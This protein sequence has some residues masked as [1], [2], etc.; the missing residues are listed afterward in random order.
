MAFNQSRRSMLKP[1]A[2]RTPQEMA[3]RDAARAQ[4]LRE[5]ADRFPVVT[6]ENAQQVI[7]W[8]AARMAE[9]TSQFSQKT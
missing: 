7:D 5:S 4:T 1:A 6:A 9:L 2:G 8:Q 3:A